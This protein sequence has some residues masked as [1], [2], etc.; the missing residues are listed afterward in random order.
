MVSVF[1]FGTIGVTYAIGLVSF[2]GLNASLTSLTYV[3]CVALSLFSQYSAI[4]VGTGD[5]ETYTLASVVVL[6]SGY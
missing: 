2:V 5:I 3:T 1:N 6:I 4:V